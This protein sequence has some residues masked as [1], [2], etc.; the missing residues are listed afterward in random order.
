MVRAGPRL[1]AGLFGVPSPPSV[2]T[3]AYA[4]AHLSSL[5]AERSARRGAVLPPLPRL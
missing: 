2:G 1:R 3:H 4:T 5:R